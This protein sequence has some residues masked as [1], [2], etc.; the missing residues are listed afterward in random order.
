[1]EIRHPLRFV[2]H[3]NHH[4]GRHLLQHKTQGR[5]ADGEDARGKLH[6]QLHA[7]RHAPEGEG[8]HHEGVQVGTE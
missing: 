3:S 6:R 5:L 7:W 1:M 4:A 2:R 8:Q